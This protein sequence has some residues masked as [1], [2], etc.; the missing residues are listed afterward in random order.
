MSYR[1]TNRDTTALP[2]EL[3]PL[4]KAQVRVDFTDDDV[5]LTSILARSIDLYERKT[6]LTIFSGTAEWSP[7]EFDNV[8]DLGIQV[9]LQPI[10]VMTVEDADGNDVTSSFKIVGNQAPGRASGLY[11]VPAADAEMPDGLAATLTLG[12]ASAAEISPA[13]LDSILRIGGHLYE[14]REAIS[15]L[16]LRDADWWADDLLVA[17][18]VPRA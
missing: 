4:F 13:T 16:L 3:L 9:P 15:D 11:F 17:G 7:D 18:W 2:T 5:L 12:A 6:G 1:I 14:N 10:S 8:T